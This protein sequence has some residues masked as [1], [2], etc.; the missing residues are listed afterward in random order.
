MTK[1]KEYLKWIRDA[2]KIARYGE[3]FLAS[4]KFTYEQYIAHMD[5]C[6]REIYEYLKN[7]YIIT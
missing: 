2:K 4:S 1:Q 3:P 5:K 7:K 6:N